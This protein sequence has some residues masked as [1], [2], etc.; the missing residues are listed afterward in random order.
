MYQLNQAAVKVS[1]IWVAIHYSFW[2]FD[3]CE[4]FLAVATVTDQQTS[5]KGGHILSENSLSW[6]EATA[7]EQQSPCW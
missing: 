3:K 5:S 6:K 1:P 4:C 2:Y 7:S